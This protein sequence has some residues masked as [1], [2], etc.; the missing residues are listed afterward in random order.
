M[1]GDQIIYIRKVK[2]DL[3]PGDEM[4]NPF[5]REVIEIYIYCAITIQKYK[6]FAARNCDH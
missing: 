1:S 5:S 6:L 3:Q 4:M 2:A